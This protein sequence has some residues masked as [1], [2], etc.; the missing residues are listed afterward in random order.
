MGSKQNLEVRLWNTVLKGKFSSPSHQRPYFVVYVILFLPL[1]LLYLL[2]SSNHKPVPSLLCHCTILW[3]LCILPRYIPWPAQ[4]SILIPHS[5][6]PWAH[7]LHC[8]FPVP[9]TFS[10]LWPFVPCLPSF[11]CPFLTWKSKFW[12]DIQCCWGVVQQELPW[13]SSS[14]V[15][16]IRSTG[17]AVCRQCFRQFLEMSW[18]DV[19]LPEGAEA[20]AWPAIA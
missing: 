7:F 4:T 5:L 10:Q 1:P 20:A 17:I 6:T 13:C 9:S 11:S 16:T 12:H 15:D 2:S 8:T 19:T 3:H 18:C 14:L